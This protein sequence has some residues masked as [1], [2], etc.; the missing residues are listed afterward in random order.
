VWG[1]AAE[2]L[3]F[4]EAY[5]RDPLRWN[6]KAS[7]L[8]M[9]ERVFCG[10]MCDVMEWPADTQIEMKWR[11]RLWDLIERTPNLDWLLVT[12]RPQNFGRLLPMKWRQEPRGNVW[13]I[14]TVESREYSGRADELLE[15][16]AVVHGLSI[17][18]MLGAMEVYGLARRLL[19]WVIIGGESGGKA[20]PFDL[21][22]ARNILAQCRAAAVPV[23]VK[24]LGTAWAKETGA[25]DRKGGNPAEWP[26]DLRVREFPEVRAA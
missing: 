24:Q 10:S 12:K 23:F 21:A 26:E 16:P 22:A 14:A 13:L 18:P 11:P 6:S 7:R 3:F 1:Q 9:R 25:R 15:V 5:W 8:G 19:D 17:E 4:G 2:R 20:R